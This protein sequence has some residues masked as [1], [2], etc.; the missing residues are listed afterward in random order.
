MN[1]PRL[2]ITPFA[3][4]G[5]KSTIPESVGALSNSA[6]WQSGFPPVT[7]TNKAAGGLAPRGQDVNG[8]LYDI[9]SNLKHLQSGGAYQ[10]DSTYAAAIG[11]YQKDALVYNSGQ[12][13]MY[14]S[15]I[16]GNTS[17]LSVTASW[18]L[19]WRSSAVADIDG[20][21]DVT[22][23]VQSTGSSESF[24]MSQKATTDAINAI[25]NTASLNINGWKRDPV[26]GAIE[27]WG[28]VDY[29]SRPEESDVTVP[30][31]ISFPNQCLNVQLTRK[32]IANASRTS[33]DGGM[34]LVSASASSFVANRAEFSEDSSG[35][36]GFTWRAIGR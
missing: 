33:N 11:G 3:E 34:L 14:Q 27:Q 8:V 16:D 22:S 30:F 13:A 7:M 21:L 36:R 18:R 35:I 24:V 19:V 2:I 15:L 28:T 29:S 9:T 1:N 4:V 12:S 23:V 17:A 31:V 20:K 25:K 10:F 26:T 6:T 32:V 5:D